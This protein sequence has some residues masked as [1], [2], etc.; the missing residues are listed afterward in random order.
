MDL[1]GDT[2]TVYVNSI[3]VQHRLSSD[4]TR[5]AGGCCTATR[6]GPVP[7]APAATAARPA[8]AGDSNDPGQVDA[9]ECVR[10][11]KGRDAD[12]WKVNN[13]CKFGIRVVYQA[14]SST[15]RNYLGPAPSAGD[16]VISKTEPR[17]ISACAQNAAGC[18]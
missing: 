7:A 3:T 5:L 1:L 14:G 12:T 10:I 18:K 17:L 16:G 4:R 15:A 11:A 2:I 6:L 8:R 13:V 9:K